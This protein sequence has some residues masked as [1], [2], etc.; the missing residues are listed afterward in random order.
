MRE[1]KGSR[2]SRRKAHKVYVGKEELSSVVAAESIHLNDYES[3]S[4]VNYSEEFAHFFAANCLQ[5]MCLCFNELKAV[6][7]IQNVYFNICSN[8]YG[9]NISNGSDKSYRLVLRD[10]S[11]LEK[12]GLPVP[13]HRS[14]DPCLTITAHEKFISVVMMRISNVPHSNDFKF[15]FIRDPVGPLRL[16][17]FIF[18]LIELHWTPLKNDFSPLLLFVY[19]TSFS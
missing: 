16:Y 15:T 9:I 12:L 4:S 13:T 10:Y 6:E 14:G 2:M 18:W 19:I 17:L 3:F 1:K 5:V 7:D 8:V 11:M